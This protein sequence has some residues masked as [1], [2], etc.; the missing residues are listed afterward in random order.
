[1]VDD[2]PEEPVRLYFD[3]V[4]ETGPFRARIDAD[5]GALGCPININY[6]YGIVNTYF[7]R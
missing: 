2:R 1:M 7:E 5:N 6:E 4:L 3:Q